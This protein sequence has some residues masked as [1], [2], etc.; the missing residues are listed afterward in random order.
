MTSSLKML[1]LINLFV[2]IMLTSYLIIHIILLQNY[3]DE[4]LATLNNISGP[5]LF[6]RY[7]CKLFTYSWS[8]VFNTLDIIASSEFILT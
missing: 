2:L 5:M 1:F 8:L 3:N 4:I 6:N 7:F